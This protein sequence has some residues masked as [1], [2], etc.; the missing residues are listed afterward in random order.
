MSY[1]LSV[2]TNIVDAGILDGGGKTIT[3]SREGLLATAFSAWMETANA[4]GH[5]SYD[6]RT[7]PNSPSFTLGY[8]QYGSILTIL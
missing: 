6:F 2:E 3:T 7:I 1:T 8:N 5:A 4:S